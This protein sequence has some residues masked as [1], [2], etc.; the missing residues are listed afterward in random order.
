M[1]SSRAIKERVPDACDGHHWHHP[2]AA[3]LPAKW[4]DNL[5]KRVLNAVLRELQELNCSVVF[6]AEEEAEELEEFGLMDGILG[7]EDLGEQL[8]PPIHSH[9][10]GRDAVD[11]ASTQ[12]PKHRITATTGPDRNR[13]RSQQEVAGHTAQQA[14][15]DPEVAT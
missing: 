11:P 15:G 2:G 6:A 14:A 12:N 1:T 4:S 8:P 5:A 10:L 13:E 9:Q 3:Q 7:E